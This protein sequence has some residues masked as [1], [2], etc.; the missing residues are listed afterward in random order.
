MTLYA[1]SKLIITV[2]SDRQVEKATAQWL[3]FPGGLNPKMASPFALGS[4]PRCRF[5]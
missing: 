1:Y 4:R 2:H 3:K 5:Y